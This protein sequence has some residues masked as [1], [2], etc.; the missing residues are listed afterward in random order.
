[1]NVFKNSKK[2]FVG[3]TTLIIIFLHFGKISHQ[4]FDI[5]NNK[6]NLFIFKDPITI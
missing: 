1:M 4:K 2:A 5:N 3:V 6:H